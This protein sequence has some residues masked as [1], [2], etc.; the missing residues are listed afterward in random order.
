MCHV[1]GSGCE[2]KKKLR[3]DRNRGMFVSGFV[4]S[5]YVN[6]GVDYFTVEVQGIYCGSEEV[7]EQLG[8]GFISGCP[9]PVQSA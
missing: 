4:G 9:I 3:S 8:M 6:M 7:E 5:K 1:V 2:L